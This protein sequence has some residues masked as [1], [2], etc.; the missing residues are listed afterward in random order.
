[1]NQAR[2]GWTNRTLS[3]LLW[4]SL[5]TGA[6]AVLQLVVLAILARLLT[7]ADFGLAAAALV[8]VGFSAVFSQLGIGPAVVQRLDLEPAHLRS[9]FTISVLLGVLLGGLVW[10]TA[11]LVALFF[12]LEGLTPLLRVL[13]F[14]FPVQ[15]LGVVADSLLQRE[16]RFRGLA[17]VEAVTVAAGYGVAGVPLAALGYGAWA[18]VAA[19]LV[20]NALRT[21]LLFTL[22]PHPVRPLLDRRASAELLY[23]GGGYTASRFSN[24][25]AGQGDNLVVGRWLGAEALGDYGRAYQLM[26]GPAVVFGNILDRV[27]FPT[28]AQMQHQPERLAEAYR[29]GVALIALVMLPATALLILLAPELTRVVLGPEWDEV[30]LP[31]QVLGAGLLFRT[32]YKLS[33]SLVRATGAVYQR[34][35]RQVVYALVVLGGAWVGQFGGLPGVALAVLATLALNFFLMAHLSLKESGLSWRRFAAAHLPGLALGTLV[36]ANAWAV[37]A[38]LRAWGLP[39]PVVL[40]GAVAGTLPSLLLAKRLPGVFLGED[41]RWML[42]KL[43]AYVLGGS[44]A[45]RAPREPVPPAPLTEEAVS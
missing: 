44:R 1:M 23:F 26:A 22:R 36:A 34:T 37:V 31:L 10:T 17:A 11:P 41:G 9:A 15:G 12:R 2:G 21:V 30:V 16:L 14:V 39:A 3:G 24:Y 42:R 33:D 13:A 43:T 29:R 35:W 5:G 38:L 32:S 19:H 28:M 20:Q 8:V 27:L 45:V 25:A 4:T 6:Q 7:P 40:A 18:L